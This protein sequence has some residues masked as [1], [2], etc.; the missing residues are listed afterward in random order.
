LIF[1]AVTP[2]PARSDVPTHPVHCTSVAI[3]AAIACCTGGAKNEPV[4][5]AA[6]AMIEATLTLIMDFVN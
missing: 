1:A 4:A 5:N 6:I 2:L 3:T